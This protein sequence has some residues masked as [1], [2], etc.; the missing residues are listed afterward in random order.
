MFRLHLHPV[1]RDHIPHMGTQELLDLY[2]QLVHAQLN[3]GG[4]EFDGEIHQIE[5]E[6]EKRF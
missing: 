6:L 1:Y 3:H 5:T 2:A 4:T